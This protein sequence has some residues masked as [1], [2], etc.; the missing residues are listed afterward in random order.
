MTLYILHF[1][2]SRADDEY[3]GRESVHRRHLA[4]LLPAL[5]PAPMPSRGFAFFFGADAASS[6]PPSMAELRRF[7][8]GRSAGNATVATV[9][10]SS[11]T[12]IGESILPLTAGESAAVVGKGVAAACWA[13]AALAVAMLATAG[14]RL[15]RNARIQIDSR[16]VGISES[17]AH[18]A[19]TVGRSADGPPVATVSIAPAPMRARST[20][21]PFCAQVRAVAGRLVDG[22]AAS[23]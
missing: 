1:V 12:T 7:F 11:T 14:R 6:A 17:N 5:A 4:L 18:W 3:T 23:V 22:G 8:D 2:S 13:A 21:L 20:K 10:L 15:R 9:G 19:P 16:A